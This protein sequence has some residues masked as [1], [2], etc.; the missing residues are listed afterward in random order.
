MLFT[1][2][3]SVAAGA[4]APMAQPHVLN[5]LE[6]A[7]G[8]DRMPDERGQAVL[9]FAALLLAAAIVLLL[10]DART[11]PVLMI[12]GAV[13]GYFQAEI[14]EMITNRKA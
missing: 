9:V 1:L 2:I 14:R 13:A 4:L 10:V 8:A 5:A 3:V 12:V 7:L 6:R 11:S